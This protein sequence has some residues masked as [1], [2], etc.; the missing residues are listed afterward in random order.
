VVFAA[1]ATFLYFG[2][3]GLVLGSFNASLARSR[4]VPIDWLQTGFVV[5][6]AV[7]INVC[8]RVVGVLLIN[9]LLIVPAAIAMNVSS[10]LRRMFWTTVCCS[11]GLSVIGQVLSWE[12]QIRAEVPV[13]ISGV[14]V[15]LAVIV[16][17]AT[18]P[19][20]RRSRHSA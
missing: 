18:L 11:V 14:I 8:L 12:I 9:A 4:A 19:F 3:N 2:F 20:A 13:G 6:L 17:L 15:S 7:V 5:L 16:F 10:N 1:T